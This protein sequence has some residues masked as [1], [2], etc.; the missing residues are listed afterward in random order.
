MTAAQQAFV[1][2]R[3]RA[4]FARDAFETIVVPRLEI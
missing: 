3:Y 2:D 1:L 4:K